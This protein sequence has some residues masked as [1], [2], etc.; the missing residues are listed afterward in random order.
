MHD[1]DNYG[2]PRRW[3]APV[4]ALAVLVVVAMILALVGGFVAVVFG[5]A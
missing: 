1:D 4:M 2:P 5:A 3:S